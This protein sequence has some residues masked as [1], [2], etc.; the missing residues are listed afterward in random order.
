[1]TAVWL[2]ALNFVREQRWFILLMLT[3][4]FGITGLLA[5]VERDANDALV[6]F[7]QEAAYGLF[8]AV[9]IA[10][11]VFQNERK[12]RRIVA[13]LSKAVARREYV[14]GIIVGVTLT[15]AVFY[16]AVTLSVFVLFPAVRVGGVLLMIVTMMTAALLATVV[17]VLYA[18]FMHPLAATAS[19]GLTLALPFL[20]ER[21]APAWARVLPMSALVG[22]ALR[23]SPENGVAFDGAAIAVALAWCAALWIVASWIF[24]LR[25]ITTPVE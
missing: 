12:T 14:A 7:K 1:M 20:L 2:I 5:A 21:M 4:I 3:Y 13:V 18:T 24:S 9:V 11:A 23:F 16:A 15:V 10:A 19:A 22:T 8:F 25:D 6:I 17:T